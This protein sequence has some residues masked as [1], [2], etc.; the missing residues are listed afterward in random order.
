MD[1]ILLLKALILG[2]VEGLTEFLPISSTGHLIV[3]GDLLNFHSNGKVF[4]IAIQL[5]AVLAV[6]FEYRQRFSK[7]I[8]GIG[9]ERTA[10]RFVLNLAVAFVPAAVVG[11]LF[12]KQIKLYLFNPITVAM[13]LVLG[14]FFIL[15]VEKRQQSRAPK[16]VNVDD[17][18][19]ID[20]F[21]VGCAQICA[22]VPGTS[23][24]GS[25]IMGGMLWGLERKVATEFSFFLAVPMMIAATFYD[26][27]KHYKLFTLQDIGLI[28]VGF[29]AAFFAG[30]LA[31]K[32]LLKFLATKNYV[33]FAYY[34]IVFG[35]LILLTWAMGW[36]QWTE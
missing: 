8:R 15:W 28:A 24:S 20:A 4:E 9:K 27:L 19:P 13:M 3:V 26:I 25:T 17:M 33:P 10:N 32:A 22:L 5:G 18:R 7:I 12:S 16:V 23:R 11:L 30:L 14:G 31:V 6:I 1:I 34:R 36:V 2:I 35:G 29:I 21:V